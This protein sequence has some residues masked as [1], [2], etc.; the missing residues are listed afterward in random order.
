MHGSGWVQNFGML[1]L[2]HA[3]SVWDSIVYCAKLGARCA[4]HFVGAEARADY[5]T[6][7]ISQCRGGG[8]GVDSS[9]P[10]CPSPQYRLFN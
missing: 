2:L 6:R 8:E 10:V 5:Q 1:H 4:H 7:Q 3:F 9:Q